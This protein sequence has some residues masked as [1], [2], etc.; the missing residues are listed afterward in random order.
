MLWFM[1]IEILFDRVLI[2]PIT[3]E[4]SEKG[5]LLPPT[6][7]DNFL[8]KGRVVAV[9]KSEE[10]SVGDV[11]F[12]IETGAVPFKFEDKEYQ[13]VNLGQVMVKLK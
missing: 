4:K 2:E 6:V 9:K 8:A 7:R 5:I 3:E 12:Y 11:V 10:L 13:I 1:N